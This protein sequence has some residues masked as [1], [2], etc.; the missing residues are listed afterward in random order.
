[1]DEQVLKRAQQRVAEARTDGIAGARL[2]AALER[3]RAEVM[4]LAQVADELESS[5]PKQVGI[6][7]RDG[8]AREVVPVS[9]SLAE[10]RGGVNQALRRLER[11]EEELLAERSARIDDLAVLVDLVSAG[12]AG[13]DRRLKRLEDDIEG[14]VV[15]L[16]RARDASEPPAQAAD[17]AA[18]A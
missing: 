16:P 10:I 4:R 13:V 7:V 11:L 9:R 15:P 12:W 14:A 6:A 1:M 5:L 17:Q 2:D 18:V 8:I 3:A